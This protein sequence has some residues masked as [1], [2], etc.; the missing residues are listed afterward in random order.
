[1]E[2]KGME[3]PYPYSL[4]EAQRLG[5]MDMELYR[6][7]NRLNEE[8]AQ[9]IK[10]AINRNYDGYYLKK[11]LAKKIIEE[12]GYA[13]V[14]FVLANTIQHRK[15]D[16]R[17]SR[18]NKEWAK[19]FFIP[20]DVDGNCD[21]RNNFEIHID[22]ALINIFTNQ[23]RKENELLGLYNGSQCNSADN[24]DFEN[25]LMVLKPINLSDA[26]KNPDNQMVYCTGGFG[27]SPTARGRKVFGIFLKDGEKC[28]YHREDFIGELKPEFMP[29][30][31]KEKLKELQSPKNNQIQE[32]PMD[33]Q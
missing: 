13:R 24:I 3:Y 32:L 17:I 9:S 18:E 2:K 14:N 30:W 7:S 21:R 19:K 11:D 25:K 23:A 31:T 10:E 12:Y 16:G 20:K 6:K 33:L 26:Y 4:E 1:M 28:Q 22:A 29:D 5:K 27:C 15:N 8:C